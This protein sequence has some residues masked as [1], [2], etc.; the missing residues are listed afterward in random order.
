M[1]INQS[2]P[3]SMVRSMFL[4]LVALLSWLPNG[5]WA[6]AP[7]GSSVEAQ[8]AAMQKLAF[9]VG[10]WSGPATVSR[11]PGEPTH[12]TQAEDV[13]FKLDGLVLLIE[14]RSTDADGKSGFSAL[15][16]VA[17]DDASH[18]YRFRAY[19]GGH[20]LDTELTVTADGFS[21]SYDAGPAHVV[22]TMHVTAKGEWSETTE[23]TYGGHPPMRAVEMLLRH[24]Q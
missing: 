18:A 8:R 4:A 17:F 3:P 13:Q 1:R 2:A 11:G 10:R 5:V 9:L 23:A 7:G 24:E 15:A 12:V 14:G 22:N 20:Y 6:Q 16:T 19:N 21:W